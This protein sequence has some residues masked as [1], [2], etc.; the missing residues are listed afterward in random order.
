MQRPD[1]HGL[2][3]ELPPAE[4]IVRRLVGRQ[5]ELEELDRWLRDDEQNRWLLAGAGGRG[6]SAIAYEFARRVKEEAPNP[7]TF[8]LWMS[9]KK[10]SLI[11][12][13]IVTNP[14]PDITDLPSALDRVLDA[15]GWLTEAPEEAAARRR[16]V[17]ELLAFISSRVALFVLSSLTVA[18]VQTY[19]DRHG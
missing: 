5:A 6:K 13:H 16:L 17:L 7:L 2:E 1:H 3:S 9:A 12:G 4:L 14:S 18:S 15:L 19:A 10:R 8:V 11:D